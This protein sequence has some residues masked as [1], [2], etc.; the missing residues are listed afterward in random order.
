M[1][2]RRYLAGSTT[3]LVEGTTVWLRGNPYGT[4]FVLAAGAFGLAD[5]IPTIGGDAIAQPG[6]SW[7]GTTLTCP[8]VGGVE[9]LRQ[10]RQLAARLV[11]RLQRGRL[12]WTGYAGSGHSGG[13]GYGSV[14]SRFADGY[15]GAN[16]N[17]FPSSNLLPV[18]VIRGPM[19]Q[20]L[21]PCEQLPQE[22]REAE[23]FADAL[24]ITGILSAPLFGP[25]G[26]VSA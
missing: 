19:A 21:P 4:G 17:P 20:I 10:P 15:Y 9:T 24:A 3:A 22:T 25:I 14:N 23:D 1:G 12:R 11:L 2:G 16:S 18:R 26:R 7:D 6:C 5:G 8:P 13:G